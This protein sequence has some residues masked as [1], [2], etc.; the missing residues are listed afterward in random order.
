MPGMPD[1]ASRG[2]CRRT[3]GERSLDY[4]LIVTPNYSPHVKQHDEAESATDTDRKYVIIVLTHGGVLHEQPRGQND[5]HGNGCAHDVAAR[6][7]GDHE[8]QN[9]P[10]CDPDKQEQAALPTQRT[11]FHCGG[12]R[13]FRMPRSASAYSF[14]PLNAASLSSRRRLAVQHRP[15][16]QSTAAV[17]RSVSHALATSSSENLKKPRLSDLF[18]GDVTLK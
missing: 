1:E 7:T 13:V 15:S 5:N 8:I 9:P 12:G 11:L 14:S 3:A 10:G 2:V 18:S 17:R 16:A 4:F 6:G